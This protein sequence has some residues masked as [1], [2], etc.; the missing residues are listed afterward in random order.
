VESGSFYGHK[1]PESRGTART[2]FYTGVESSDIWFIGFFAVFFFAPTPLGL[3]VLAVDFFDGRSL[4]VVT[5]PGCSPFPQLRSVL[6]ESFL[7]QYLPVF[8]N[9]AR[10]G[11]QK[12]S[13]GR[14]AT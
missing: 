9:C 7:S 8:F 6:R 14:S 2:N 10:S 1:V 13:L 4:F 3:A 5:V 11:S 12:A